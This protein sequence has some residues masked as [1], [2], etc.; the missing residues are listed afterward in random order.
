[1]KH[2]SSLLLLAAFS[3]SALAQVPAA[4]DKK[5]TISRGL[6]NDYFVFEKEGKYGVVNKS[7]T[8]ILPAVYNTIYNVRFGLFVAETGSGM[9]VI[10]AKNQTVLP[11]A[12]EELDIL[13]ANRIHAQKYGLPVVLSRNGRFLADTTER[14]ARLF[15]Q[16]GDLFTPPRIV[17]D[18]LVE[19]YGENNFLRTDD[20]IFIINGDDTIRTSFEDV[21]YLAYDGHI[22]KFKKNGRWGIADAE[23][24]ELIPAEFE[25]LDGDMHTGYV[26]ATKQGKKSLLD[27]E[28]NPVPGGPFDEI[29]YF[30]RDGLSIV[31]LGDTEGIIDQSGE[32]ILQPAR[33][34]ISSY[35]D[36]LFWVRD[37]TT[38]TMDVIDRTTRS[39][40]PQGTS[41]RA[42]S[43]NLILVIT[44]DNKMG[45]VHASGLSLLRPVY[46]EVFFGNSD[47]ED[48]H[49]FMARK[50]SKWGLLDMQE[51]LVVPFQYD[52][53]ALLKKGYATAILNG[54]AGAITDRNK[55]AV[56][57]I[58]EETAS[59]FNDWHLLRVKKDGKYGFV[60]IAGTVIIPVVYDYVD[61]DF[62]K[63]LSVARKGD[64]WGY[65]DTKGKVVIPFE[66]D[67][68][69]FH[70][71]DNKTKVRKGI[72]W[73]EID[74]NGKLLGEIPSP[75]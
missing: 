28:L 63:G 12:F 46:D 20:T 68:A 27:T 38:G 61:E 15:Q 74:K 55:I 25:E 59:A 58:Y 57:F 42:A 3:F 62:E 64:K 37:E 70:F 72:T 41:A 23:G 51:N 18:E 43:G 65:L 53:I 35:A 4:L 60:N 13:S 19:A 10:N 36:I 26:I 69:F 56:P 8:I 49:F 17:M 7:G 22:V 16:N 48:D 45:A 40:L 67:E 44:P 31:K 2:L 5:F 75:K 21:E 9:G 71:Y 50:G 32:I 73:Y 24:K 47:G 66:Y 33:H 6:T 11:F 39:I 52:K 34:S 54:K 14:P 30:N 29:G 1:M